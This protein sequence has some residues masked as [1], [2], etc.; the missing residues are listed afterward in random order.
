M[1]DFWSF[2]NGVKD[3]VL[4]SDLTADCQLTSKKYKMYSGSDRVGFGPLLNIVKLP[5][6]LRANAGSFTPKTGI[7]LITDLLTKHLWVCAMCLALC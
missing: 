5:A 1:T 3:S 6:N 4:L 2:L 7:G